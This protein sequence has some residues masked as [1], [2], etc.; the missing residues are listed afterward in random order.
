MN[1]DISIEQ[2]LERPAVQQSSSVI[3]PEIA[4]DKH[5]NHLKAQHGIIGC[6]LF[7]SSVTG[8]TSSPIAQIPGR[9][10]QVAI[11]A[12]TF[13]QPTEKVSGLEK[14][15]H[16]IQALIAVTLLAVAILRYQN[17]DNCDDIDSPLCKN[18]ILLETLYSTLLLLSWGPAQVIH[19]SA[20]KPAN[21][22]SEE[23]TPRTI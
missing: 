18:E 21:S 10:L 11:S 22:A 13:F 1:R 14:F 7:T 17:G 23:T 20:K 4:S 5:S 3:S 6:Q 19:H 8:A 12:R 2:R 9:L 15:A 16:G